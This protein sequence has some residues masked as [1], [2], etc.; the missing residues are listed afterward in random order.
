M[1]PDEVYNRHDFD[2]F[3]GAHLCTTFWKFRSHSKPIGWDPNQFYNSHGFATIRS[4]FATIR[5]RD[6]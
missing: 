3:R 4:N 2:T 5:T 1:D 6:L